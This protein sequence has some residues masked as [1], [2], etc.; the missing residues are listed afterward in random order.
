MD[1]NRLTVEQVEAYLK[2]LGLVY[3][4]AWGIQFD[5]MVGHKDGVELP[6]CSH[7]CTSRVGGYDCKA[8][9]DNTGGVKLNTLAPP[10]VIEDWLVMAVEG[11]KLA[12][13]AWMEEYF[14]RYCARFRVPVIAQEAMHHA[15]TTGGGELNWF[16]GEPG[17]YPQIMRL[18]RFA[19]RLGL[20]VNLTDTGLRL[21]MDRVFMDEL[22]VDPVNVL[23]LSLDD[24]TLDEF[25]RLSQM[26]PLEIRAE[27]Q[28]LKSNKDTY[29]HGQR[30]KAYESMWVLTELYRRCDTPP[31][32]L[33]LNMV[34]WS[35]NIENVYAMT[36][37]VE[38]R[39]PGT[40]VNPY[41]DQRALDRKPGAATKAD[42]AAL[43]RFYDHAID[44]TMEG[45]RFVKRLH[46]WLK[47]KAECILWQDDYE[48]LRD[49]AAGHNG[50]R[51]YNPGSGRYLQIGQSPKATLGKYPGGH[52]GCFWPREWI[53]QQL[54]Q[55]SSAQ[56]VVDYRMGDM[57]KIAAA[58]GNWCVCDMPRLAFDK[59]NQDLGMLDITRDETPPVIPIYLDLTDEYVWSRLKAA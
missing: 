43:K 56:Q 48:T 7:N 42:L 35:G 51:C 17:K 6:L 39:F 47:K 14:Q 21:M 24:L 20:V 55:L 52:L 38:R 25:Q 53:V 19:K 49:A 57:T 16:G 1:A 15:L 22:L 34:L 54:Q 58:N 12:M 50:F 29:D 13:S 37:A 23:A 11:Q 18:I 45:G 9:I 28:K 8:A 10:E 41:T 33:L 26:S 36:E 30:Q 59:P 44:K 4:V 27:W 2:S 46:F 5:I 3:N 32:T 31:L 40:T